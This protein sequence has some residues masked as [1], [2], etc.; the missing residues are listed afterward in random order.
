MPKKT[1]LL[2][3]AAVA[4]FAGV[5]LTIIG[6][7]L[8]A[9]NGPSCDG[10]QMKSGDHC[11]AGK[12]WRMKTGQST[13][14]TFTE[15]DQYYP[16]SDLSYPPNARSYESMNSAMLPAGVALV[17]VGPL[18]LAVSIVTGYLWHRERTMHRVN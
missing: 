15:P 1:A 5:I 6:V 17:V 14:K 11:V 9:A 12:T 4:L 7:G 8:L 10:N 18:V 3:G 16:A 13:T 2:I